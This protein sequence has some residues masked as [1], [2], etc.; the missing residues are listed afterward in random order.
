MNES[1]IETYDNCYV[2]FL[3]ILGFKDLVEKNSHDE[4]IGIFE[5]IIDQVLSKR[6][7]EFNLPKEGPF[8]L[9]GEQYLVETLFI[10]DSIIL[11]TK[12]E[13]P[14]AFVKLILMILDI[15]AISFLAG[16]PL[17]GGISN[18]PISTYK[19]NN[20]T[21]I[22][23]RG[24]TNAYLIEANQNWSGCIIDESAIEE[25]NKQNEKFNSG[26]GVTFEDLKNI[27]GVITEYSVPLKSGK[28]EKQN[29]INWTKNKNIL[30]EM[31]IDDVRK[32]FSRHNKFVNDW[33]VEQIISNTVNF[34]VELK[35]GL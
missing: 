19:R 30:G 26:E 14:R 10:S 27:L 15:I 33:R 28:V 7:D 8:G 17:R 13:T 32:S 25:F 2:G 20:N 9:Q 4:L 18:G 21:T 29:V 23:G 6:I 3:D 24:L 35:N 31:T 22:I 12:N 16:I 34:F 5:T 1:K 11:W